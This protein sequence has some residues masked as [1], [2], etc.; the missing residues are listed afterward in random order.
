MQHIVRNYFPPHTFF[1]VLQ[2]SQV[3]RKGSSTNQIGPSS[4]G[5]RESHS[6]SRSRDSSSGSAKS[7]PGYMQAT[8]SSSISKGSGTPKNRKVPDK[9]R[10]CSNWLVQFFGDYLRYIFNLMHDLLWTD[11]R[12]VITFG[13]TLKSWTSQTW[14]GQRKVR[15]SGLVTRGGRSLRST[16]CWLSI[17]LSKFILFKGTAKRQPSP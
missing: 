9:K 8:R 17:L 7:V 12:V 15:Y 1:Y 5:S 3:S 14:T 2:S 6:P 10:W 4:P 11:R 13:F 16:K